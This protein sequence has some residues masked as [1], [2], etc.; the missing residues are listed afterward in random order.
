MRRHD[1]IQKA[2]DE[3]AKA[4][5]RDVQR[6][7]DEKFFR[8]FMMFYEDFLNKL[9]AEGILVGKDE[10]YEGITDRFCE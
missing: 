3:T 10:V 7:M 1:E 8:T 4:I 2:M 9:K 5:A 6:E